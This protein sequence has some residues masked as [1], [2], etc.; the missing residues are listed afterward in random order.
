[1]D[2]GSAGTGVRRHRRLGR[3]RAG[4]PPTALVADGARVVLS[5]RHAETLDA[6][7]RGAGRDARDRLVADNADPGTP[8]A[9]VDGGPVDV[10]ARS[11]GPW[12][13]SAGPPPGRSWTPP[14]RTGPPPSSR[15]SS[16]GC[17][18]AARSAASSP[19]GGS[20]AFVLSSSVKSPI[21]GLAISNGL[22]PGPGDD[23]QDPRRRARARAGSASTACCRAASRPT[24]CA[25]STSRAATRTAAQG[26]GAP[27][28]SRCAATATRRSSAGRRRSC[29]RRPRRF[30]TGVMLPVD[31]GM[32]RALRTARD[33]R[34]LAAPPAG[35]AASC[36]RRRRGRRSRTPR[37][38]RRTTTAARRRSAGRCRGR[39]ARRAPSGVGGLRRL[40]LD[41]HEAA[42]HRAGRAPCRSPRWRSARVGPVRHG[43][44]AAGGVGADPADDRDGPGRRRGGSDGLGAGVARSAI[45]PR[46][47]SRAA[48]S[49]VTQRGHHVD[50]RR[51]RHGSG[52]ARSPSRRR[53]RCRWR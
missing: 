9:L 15:C 35:S 11:T 7:G 31:G 13:P 36:A 12:S 1:M 44:R 47:T 27:R 40:G 41:V 26:A 29:S 52:S 30:V 37:A 10:R 3:P 16:A 19:P 46:S 49:A 4:P 43:R 45:Q 50:A 14:T 39:A 23:R 17:G 28:A 33:L 8:R 2:L 42:V 5:G 18:W 25:G 20:I 38:P 34:A 32:L 22:R 21:A 51:R 6:G 53:R 24:G 48:P